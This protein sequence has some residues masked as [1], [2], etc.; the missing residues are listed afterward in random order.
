MV[1]EEF[2]D[3]QSMGGVKQ[4][5]VAKYVDGTLIDIFIEWVKITT[6]LPFSYMG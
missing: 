3:F 5:G 1:H 2:V 4:A 6:T